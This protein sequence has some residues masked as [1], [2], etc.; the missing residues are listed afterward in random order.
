MFYATSNSRLCESFVIWESLWALQSVIC[1][2]GDVMTSSR[3]CVRGAVFSTDENI[4][5]RSDIVRVSHRHNMSPA[6]RVR[7]EA[8]PQHCGPRRG[9]IFWVSSLWTVI[10]EVF[11]KSFELFLGRGVWLFQ[12]KHFVSRV[13]VRGLSAGDIIMAVSPSM[14]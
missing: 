4:V 10:E 7:G 9:G 6:P 14:P 3:L 1:I 13:W 12:L 5:T 2:D 8:H 11:L